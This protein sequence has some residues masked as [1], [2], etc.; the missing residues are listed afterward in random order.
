MLLLMQ[1]LLKDVLHCLNGYR[2]TA[3]VSVTVL[4]YSS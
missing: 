2:N 1:A 3:S 4:H